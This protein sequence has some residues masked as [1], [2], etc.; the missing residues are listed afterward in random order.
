DPVLYDYFVAWDERSENER[1][2][3]NVELW[4]ALNGQWEA[5]W[6]LAQL[7]YDQFL[8]QEAKAKKRLG[9]GHPLCNLA[10][11][12]RQIGSPTLTRHYATLS[13]AGDV[14]MEHQF[15]D[16]RHGGLGP[17]MLEQFESQEQ[18]QA[19]REK[20]RNDLKAISPDKP[21]YVESFQAGRWFSE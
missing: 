9:K 7:H 3:L 2:P 13:S 19:W 11:V 10:I 16:L 1:K 8:K 21:I 6:A 15:P 17:T 4:L 18:Q 14:Y 20:I 5:A 12:G